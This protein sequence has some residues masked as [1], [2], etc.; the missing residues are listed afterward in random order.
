[1]KPKYLKLH[2]I[3]SFLFVILIATSAC[4]NK[5]NA[6]NTMNT[7]EPN[8]TEV[9]LPNSYSIVFSF[10]SIGSGSDW[11]IIGEMDAFL[12]AYKQSGKSQPE[13]DRIPWGR[14]GE[15]DFCIQTGQMKSTERESFRNSVMEIARRAKFVHINENAVCRYKR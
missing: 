1:M 5:K 2:Q 12:D 10:Y 13:V 4:K 15:V 11:D 3:S 14:E 9:S 8:P 7:P 6:A